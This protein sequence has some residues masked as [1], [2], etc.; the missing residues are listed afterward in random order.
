MKRRSKSF[1]RNLLEA[2]V[3]IGLIGLVAAIVI[4]IRVSFDNGVREGRE[5]LSEEISKDLNELGTI[6]S[7]KAG[8]AKTIQ[9]KLS[10][11]PKEINTE[12]IDEQIKKLE[13]LVNEVESD[14]IK[15]VLNEYLEKWKSFKEEYASKDNNAISDAFDTLRA[16]TQDVAS[17]IKNLYD[18]A[19]KTVIDKL[20]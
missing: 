6:V 11:V 18:E 8:L 14:E 1:N 7:E 20:K 5:K 15:P 19:M 9:E 13:E 16:D 12:K 10:D 2:G 4:G 3:V 17:K